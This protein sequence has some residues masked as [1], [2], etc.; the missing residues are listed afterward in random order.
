MDVKMPLMN[1]IEAARKI[2]ERWPEN[3]PK[4][5]A[6]TA[7][8]LHGDKEKCLAAGMDS[9]IPKPVQKEDLAEVL[10]KYQSSKDGP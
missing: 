6:V 5:I 10:N 9:Y 4:I 1:G 8:A 2:R 3:G 7:Y